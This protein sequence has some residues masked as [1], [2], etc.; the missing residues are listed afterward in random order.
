MNHLDSFDLPS[1]E[2]VLKSIS[3]SAL[4]LEFYVFFCHDAITMHHFHHWF[5]MIWRDLLS[6]LD[7][8]MQSARLD[9]ELGRLSQPASPDDSD[10][11]CPSETPNE[12]IIFDPSAP[13]DAWL[14]VFPPRWRMWRWHLILTCRHDVWLL[15]IGRC[16]WGGCEGAQ[17]IQSGWQ[18]LGSK[19]SHAVGPQDKYQGMQR[20]KRNNR[21]KEDWPQVM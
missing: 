20:S 9:G 12:R 8:A 5:V 13:L 21:S 17:K 14:L 7:L 11:R 19:T 15:F 4:I 10:D 18:S 6:Y 16:Y 1:K 2:R 3:L